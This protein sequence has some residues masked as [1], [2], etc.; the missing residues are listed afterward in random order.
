MKIEDYDLAAFYSRVNYIHGGVAIYVKST[1]DVES[2]DEINGLS[3]DKTFECC[4]LRCKALNILIISIYRSPDG[5]FNLFLERFDDLLVM[6]S[7]DMKIELY[8]CADFNI[9]LFNATDV[10][11]KKFLNLLTCYNLITTIKDATRVTNVS[12]TLID[13]IVVREAND[14]IQAKCLDL[15]ISDHF[16]LLLEFTITSPVSKPVPQTKLSRFFTR[17]NKFH[18]Q[19]LLQKES[20]ADVYNSID[21]NAAY[22]SF[23]DSLSYIFEISF[24]KISR[25]VKPSDASDKN[26][27]TQ[28]IRALSIYKRKL[29]QRM[30][31][32][33]K[34]NFDMSQVNEHYA[35][36]CKDM[37]ELVIRSKRDHNASLILN[38]TNKSSAMWKL[39]HKFNGNR[40]KATFGF[41]SAFMIAGKE[42]CDT[43]AVANEFNDPYINVTKRL[44]LQKPVLKSGYGYAQ[45]VHSLFL[46]PC[47]ET[48]VHDIILTLKNTLDG[49]RFQYLY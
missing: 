19:Y 2:M 37:K 13:N 49:M 31:I 6:L 5:D 45:N 21:P 17:E 47:T 8:I 36:V 11:T 41:P 20:W 12:E 40:K 44:N 29:H 32:L 48:E 43:D 35:K 4:A 42:V 7:R 16:G 24:P 3:L 38:A 23:S 15:M 28:E 18:F 9:N 10:K 34:D 25:R 33:A 30:K 22:Q 26:W 46:Q 1:Y 27:L 39:I 14:A